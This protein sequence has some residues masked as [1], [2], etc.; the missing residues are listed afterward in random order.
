ML[1]ANL[2]AELQTLQGQ[3]L[4]ADAALAAPEEATFLAISQRLSRTAPERLRRA[5]VEQ[6]IL[7]N[8]AGEKF[9]L[10]GSMFFTRDALEQATAE[11]VSSYRATRFRQAGIVFDLG[12][13]IGG[14]TL[15]LARQADVVSVD[16][17][18][19]L[20]R[21]LEY[22]AEIH[23]VSQRVSLVQGDLL[24]PAWSWPRD[25]LA[26][27]DPARR[28]GG[29]RLR[30]VEA[31]QPPLSAI[32]RHAP[33]IMGMGVKLSPA[34]DLA[35]IDASDAEVEFISFGKDLREAVLWLGSLRS[36]AR[37]ATV[38]PGP[39]SL[40]G[41]EPS[42]ADVRRLGDFL[43]EPDASV[44]RAGLVRC[45]GRQI[46]AGQL[47]PTIGLLTSD[48]MQSTPFATTYRVLEAMPFSR[49]RLQSMLD[50]RQAGSVTIKK[51]GSAVDIEALTRSLKLKGTG[52]VTVLLTR[53]A[54]RRLILVLDRVPGD[55]V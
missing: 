15:A 31:Y 29:K 32:L 18:S 2:L 41:E 51:R 26:F 14:D 6:A 22:H 28:S 16:R 24:S 45:L 43:F 54:G 25:S 8:R 36:A 9:S 39:Y 11:P 52:D 7:R 44:L 3:R 40:T 49:K 10:A 48:V 30:G 13:G 33:R 38:L 34:V 47:D 20:L 37:R 4:L 53:A 23:G 19:L 12:C 42:A 5:A 17:E 27:A 35:S 46:D 21:I 50:Q 1:D 55:K